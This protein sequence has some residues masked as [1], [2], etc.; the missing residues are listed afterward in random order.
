MIPSTSLQ[1]AVALLTVAVDARDEDELH[2]LVAEFGKK[3]DSAE[4]LLAVVALCRSL[5]LAVSK[6]VHLVDDELSNVQ[7]D[8]LT[9]DE[10]LPIALHVVRSYGAAA[11]RN[12][13]RRPDELRPAG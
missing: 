3:D 2:A 6:M 8:A 10:L 7:A 11:A 5:C 1:D 12:A 4:L 13:E 9:E